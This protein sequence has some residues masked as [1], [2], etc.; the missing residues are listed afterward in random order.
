MLTHHIA[1]GNDAV[2]VSADFLRIDCGN[3]SAIVIIQIMKA[4]LRIFMKLIHAVLISNEEDDIHLKS[5]QI[6]HVHVLIAVGHTDPFASQ[7]CICHLEL[8]LNI[9]IRGG[10]YIMH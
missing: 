3:I 7:L 1:I 4:R 5:G 9:S 10:E 8:T 2:I 6:L